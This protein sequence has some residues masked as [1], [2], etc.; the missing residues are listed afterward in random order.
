V[1]RRLSFGLYKQER[2][3]YKKG[4]DKM[5]VQEIVRLPRWVIGDALDML[6]IVGLIAVMPYVVGKIV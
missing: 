1:K 6:W 4:M 5:T 3:R 2:V